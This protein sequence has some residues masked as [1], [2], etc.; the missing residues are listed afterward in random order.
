M[1][2]EET[3]Y[4]SVAIDADVASKVKDYLMAVSPSLDAACAIPTYDLWAKDVPVEAAAEYR[5][6]ESEESYWSNKL[7]ALNDAYK[8]LTS[9]NIDIDYTELL[10]RTREAARY[11][12]YYR[13]EAHK[14]EAKFPGIERT[15]DYIFNDNINNHDPISDRRWRQLERKRY[16]INSCDTIGTYAAYKSFLSP[17][18]DNIAAARKY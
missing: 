5:Q 14:L 8:N 7:L 18:M 11:A 2:D 16:S 3:K 9:Y 6:I 13:N 12:E 1:S 10:L 17:Y 15:T 4:D